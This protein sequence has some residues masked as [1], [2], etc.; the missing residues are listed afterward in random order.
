MVTIFVSNMD[1]SVRFYTEVLGLKLEQRWG[2]EFAMLQ[3][4]D[5][6][7]IGLHPA[8]SKSPA[9][10]IKIGFQSQ[11]PIQGAVDK[12]KEQG[13]KFSTS[14]VD[15]GEVSAADFTDPDGA[16]LYLVQVKQSWQS[17]A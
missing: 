14:V 15:D 5:G 12:L 17:S 3:G 11:G 13:V 7:T 9:G 8:S 16:E 2:N 6:L 4:R 10:K 1:A